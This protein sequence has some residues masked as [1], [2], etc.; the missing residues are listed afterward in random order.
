[1]RTFTIDLSWPHPYLWRNRNRS[2][3]AQYR[4]YQDQKDEA[5]Y[6]TCQAVGVVDPPT[7][8]RIKMV[9][10]PPH[11]R[12]FD[13]SGV[14]EACKA[15]FDGLAMALGVDDSIFKHDGIERTAPAKPGM[16]YLVVTT[17]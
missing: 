9:I 11:R 17:E 16:V 1:M 4:P 3:I 7:A 10:T 5:Y 15:A 12:R 8:V 13:D 14:F 6:L 2:G